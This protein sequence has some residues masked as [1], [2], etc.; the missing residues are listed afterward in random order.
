V[1]LIAQTWVAAM[2]VPDPAG[3]IASG[4]PGRTAFYDVA[5][6]A[7]GPWLGT[8][9]AVATAIA[10]GIPDSMVAH[11]VISRLL[12]AWPATGNC[13]RSWPRCR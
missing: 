3:L 7:G 10:W 1:L 12:Y 6:I 2:L 11:V 5:A 8:V 9:C 13:P 4:D